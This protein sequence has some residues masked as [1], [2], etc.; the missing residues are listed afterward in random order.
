MPGLLVYC[1]EWV[2]GAGGGSAFHAPCPAICSGVCQEAQRVGNS[3]GKALIQGGARIYNSIEVLIL[4][5]LRLFWKEGSYTVDE[6]NQALFLVFFRLSSVDGFF[7]GTEKGNLG[8]YRFKHFG[9]QRHACYSQCSR[10]NCFTTMKTPYKVLLFLKRTEH[11][12]SLYGTGR[13]R[14]STQ[15]HTFWLLWALHTLTPHHHGEKP[16]GSVLSS[17]MTIWQ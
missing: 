11:S 6:A 5:L 17:Q 9:R 8:F 1:W 3:P 2:A 10:S 16:N 12:Q 15:M 4:F 7:L 13:G 14:K